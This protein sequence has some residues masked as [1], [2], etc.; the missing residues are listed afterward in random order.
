MVGNVDLKCQIHFPPLYRFPPN[1]L[2]GPNYNTV[3]FSCIISPILQTERKGLKR[4]NVTCLEPPS[5]GKAGILTKAFWPHK[6]PSNY[7]ARPVIYILK[8]VQISF[9]H[10]SSRNS[11]LICI[12]VCLYKCAL[13]YSLLKMFLINCGMACLLRCTEMK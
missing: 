10:Y 12:Q 8:M 1:G 2:P 13:S 9:S 4:K 5:H 7:S 3:R 6:W 11:G